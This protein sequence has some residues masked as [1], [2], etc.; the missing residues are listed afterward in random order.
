MKQDAPCL[1]CLKL[2]SATDQDTTVTATGVYIDTIK[3][4]AQC[5]T[6]ETVPTVGV[7]THSYLRSTN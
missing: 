5:A 4:N 7:S 1:H 2:H 3:K 6:L